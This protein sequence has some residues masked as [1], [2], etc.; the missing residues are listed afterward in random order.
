MAAKRG[1]IPGSVRLGFNG[2]LEATVRTAH[3][4]PV[5]SAITE[6]QEATVAKDIEALVD[7]LGK[8]AKVPLKISAEGA[9]NTVRVV[10]LFASNLQKKMM[11]KASQRDLM[12]ELIAERTSKETLL[13][14][15]AEVE[16]QLERAKANK[17]S[18]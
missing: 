13:A 11:P 6:A 15:L 16:A 7:E 17:R 18:A 1:A 3:N 4:L 14:R 8:E 9:P 5:G 2:Y 12:A 10:E